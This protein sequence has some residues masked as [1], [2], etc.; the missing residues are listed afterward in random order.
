[1]KPIFFSSPAEFRK[2][3]TANHTKAT[4]LLVGFHKVGS[5]KPSLTWPQAVD[6]ALCYG[7][8]DSVGKSLGAHSYTIRFTPRRPRSFWSNKNIA[9][10]TRLTKAGRMRAAGRKA[11]AA[12]TDERSGAYSFEKE[13]IVFD[14]L[15]AKRF[16]ASR[17]AWDFFGA[18]PPG[19]QK[20]MR[21][22]VMS[23][24][25]EETRIK[26]LSRIIEM[27][28]KKQRV[29]LEFPFGKKK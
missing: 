11:F 16:R 26:R 21:H 13:E 19:Y 10:A 14:A 27:S 22:W 24:K 17:A 15:L 1:L 23:A 29:D 9:S 8:I 12:R 5:G 4:E 20:T 18:Q 28:A 6:E 3:L 25:H 2:W 7:W